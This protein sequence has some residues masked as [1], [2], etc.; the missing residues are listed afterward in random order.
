MNYPASSVVE[1]S[2]NKTELGI[3][4]GIDNWTAEIATIAS[5]DKVMLNSKEPLKYYIHRSLLS[6][7]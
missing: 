3:S 4:V 6:T 5:N 7:T 1:M 2:V